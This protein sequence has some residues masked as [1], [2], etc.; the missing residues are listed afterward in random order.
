[1]ILRLP[2]ISPGRWRLHVLVV[3]AMLALPAL[4]QQ[5]PPEKPEQQQPIE[6]DLYQQALQSIA[7]GRKDDA[8]EALMQVIESEPDNAGAYMEVALIQCSLGRSDEAERLFATIETRFNPPQGILDVIANARDSGCASWKPLTSAS[9]TTGRGYDHNV[10]QGARN[11]SYIV[12]RDGG[13]IEVVELLEDFLPQSDHYTMLAADYMREITPNG[14]V[15]FVQLTARRNDSLRRYDSKTLYAGVEAPY[16]FGEWTMRTTATAGLVELGG[17][18]YQQ[19]VQLQARVG[20]P[21][22]LPSGMQF[23]AIGG[24]TVSRF[25]ALTNFNAVTYELR[26]QLTYRTDDFYL[27]ASAGFALDRARADRPGGDRSGPLLS[28]LLRKPFVAGSTLELG[29]S[30]QAWDSRTPYLPG[31]IYQV[32]NQ[33][34]HIGRATVVYPLA[35][36]HSLQLEG[37]MVHN[38][39]NISF[40]QY[41]NRILQLSWQ[42]QFP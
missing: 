37:R 19:Q 40:F 11:P 26:G 6:K 18:M 4:A 12:E 36:N 24:I 25:M 10:N 21:L 13:E 33:R 5:Q 31:V 32:R 16:R 29:Y 35:R 38:T 28:L 30:A 9:V 41:N 27:S 34:T 3:L 23:N 15:G 14:S 39:E 2:S 8:S 1:M 17:K 7:E 42:W 20:P 22:G